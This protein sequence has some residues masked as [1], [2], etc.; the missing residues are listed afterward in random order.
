MIL[1]VALEVPL[2][3]AKGLA[4]GQLER[5]GGVVRDIASKHVVMWLREG[6]QIDSNTDLAG[7]LLKTVL[8]AS[9]GG[10]ASTLTGLVDTAVTARSHFI[11]LQQ[12][13]GLTNLVGLVGGVGVLNLAATVIST[14]IILKRLNDLEQAIRELDIAIAKQFAQD[15]QVKMDAAIQAAEDALSMESP[16]NRISRADSALDK[17]YEARQHIWLEIDTLKGSSRYT[18]NNDLMQKNILQGMQLDW[19]R[20][21]C[22][23]E[24]GEVRRAKAYL[25][26]KLNDYR[27]TSR[28]LVHRHLGTH[29]SAYFHNSV[30]ESD[31]FRY[32]AIEH[33]LRADE[34]RLLEILI[35][36]RR[37]F[38]NKDVADEN[39]I[40]K[41][42]KQRYIDALTQSE[43]LIENHRRFKGLPCGNRSD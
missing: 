3:I 40:K 11:I 43:L 34:N 19:L 18:A 29:R 14:G 9:S 24:L 31:M 39:N 16:S 10:M 6:G 41:P 30:R 1:E 15:R 5:V 38:W 21:R 36:N 32:I 26:S 22:L 27:E 37:D 2:V 8:Q 28:S 33:W 25:D 23:L 20:S 4:S 7:G 42:G 13:Q 12:L 35:A 17:L